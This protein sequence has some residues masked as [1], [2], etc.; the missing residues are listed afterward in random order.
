[1]S[2]FDTLPRYRMVALDLDG[3]TLNSHHQL[4]DRTI[5]GLRR[6]SEKG[7]K[8]AI[9]TGRSGLSVTELLQQLQLQQDVP[10]ICYNGA[11]GLTLPSAGGPPIPHFSSPLIPESAKLVLN[12]A[13]KLGLV[14][15]YYNG[16]TGDVYAVP[17]NEDHETLLKRYAFFTGRDQVLMSSYETA[18]QICPSAK[19]LIMTNNVDALIS[20]AAEH[21]P[22][23]A[24]QIIRGSP[25]PGFF[26]EFLSP[27][28]TK[29]EGLRRICLNLNIP[30]SEVIAFGDGD[31]DKEML[32]YAGLGVAMK[33][34]CEVAKTA[35]NV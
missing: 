22:I 30:L 13:K 26:V 33:N 14:A 8:I 18:L 16:L 9:A 19:I 2:S 24:F 32:Q 5:H 35:A 4:S 3:T 7:F 15:Q 21:L 6:L 27:G 1:M 31:N 17:A 23:D 34:A 12:L 11:V 10:I 29:G 28:V 25:S 20:A